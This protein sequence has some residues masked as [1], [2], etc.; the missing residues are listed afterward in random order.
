VPTSLRTDTAGHYLIS[1]L[2]I[3]NHTLRISAAGYRPMVAAIAV[4][5]EPLRLDVTLTAMPVELE[6]IRILATTDLASASRVLSESGSWSVTQDVIERSPVLDE[7]DVLRILGT[8]SQV[9]MAPEAPATMHVRGGSADQNLLLLDGVPVYNAIHSGEIFSAFN[10]DMIGSVSLHGGVPSAE[11]G[12]RLS[13]VV[14]V[15]TRPASHEHLGARGAF[16]ATAARA[17]VDLPLSKLRGSLSLSGRH[18]YAGITHRNDSSYAGTSH[19]ADFLGRASFALP[20]GEAEVLLF[21]SADQLFFGPAPSV[22]G[23]VP[24]N[25]PAPAAAVPTRFHWS[26][27]TSA[28]IW[29]HVSGTGINAETRIWHTG[30][31]AAFDWP[32]A[33]GIGHLASAAHNDGTSGIISRSDK[34]GVNTASITVDRFPARYAIS[35]YVA[36]T[37]SPSYPNPLELTSKP[38]RASVSAERRHVINSRWTASAGVRVAAMSGTKAGIDP[39]LSVGYSPIERVAVSV[40]YAR[41]HQYIQ[42]LRNEESLLDAVIGIDLPAAF[43]APGIP[44]ATGDELVAIGTFPLGE[45]SRVTLNTYTRWASGLV[46]VAPVSIQPFATQSFAHGVGRASGGA[47]TIEGVAGRLTWNGVYAFNEV[48]RAAFTKSYHP[49]FAPTHSASLGGSYLLGQSTQL[50]LALWAAKGRPTTSVT[51]GFGWEWQGSISRA[52]KI[53]GLPLSAPGVVSGQ[54]LPVYFRVDAGARRDFT[55]GHSLPH[56]TAFAN[57]DN[58]LDRRNT[59]GYAIAADSTNRQALRMMPLSATFGLEWRF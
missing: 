15:R 32:T 42:S 12:G 14:D 57:V 43:G 26:T 10:P 41:Q 22:S 20:G 33:A 16:G 27:L 59:I 21:S 52:R 31:A 37:T 6:N 19:W 28:F 55:I 56:F 45:S 23:P 2:G 13:S 5:G 39:R 53:S 8:S 25:P 58:I 46:L 50:R 35:E 3:G 49:S 34:N 30:S 7:P 17:T 4:S 1:N 54:Q 11:Y 29:R 44:V 18:S 9:Q 48:R 36:P 47:L 24:G 38:L 51:G 40:G